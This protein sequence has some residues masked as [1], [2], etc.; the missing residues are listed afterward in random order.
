MYKL[1]VLMQQNRIDHAF[2][3]AAV[4]LVLIVLLVKAAK[5]VIGAAKSM[6]T[7]LHGLQGTANFSAGKLPICCVTVLAEFLAHHLQA[8]VTD[9][10]N[11]LPFMIQKP[12]LGGDPPHGKLSSPTLQ[13]L[14][15]GG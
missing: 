5:H 4:F 12:H 13:V 10:D 6:V 14:K 7:W 11:N 9:F 15:N 2:L 8:L 3:V 1:P